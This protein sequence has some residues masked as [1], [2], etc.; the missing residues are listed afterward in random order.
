MVDIGKLY[1]SIY[2]SLIS[3]HN[4]DVAEKEA[5]EKSEQERMQRREEQIGIIDEKI[6]EILPYQ[7]AAQAFTLVTYSPSQFS[8]KDIDIKSLERLYYMTTTDNAQKQSAWDTLYID[9][10]RGIEYNKQLRIKLTSQLSTTFSSKSSHQCNDRCKK[11]LKGTQVQRLIG[12]I[13]EI[14]EKYTPRILAAKPY[15]AP[16]SISTPLFGMT[17]KPFPVTDGCLSLTKQLF[18]GYFLEDD[19]TL[20]LPCT[21]S[22]TTLFQVVSSLSEK[23]MS[24]IR[25]YIIPFLCYTPPTQYLVHYIDMCLLDSSAL[26]ILSPLEGF[27]NAICPVPTSAKEALSELSTL[28]KTVV[29]SDERSA[30][31]VVYRYN[32]SYSDQQINSQMQ[33]LCANAAHYNIK[34][35]IVQE[36]SPKAGNLDQVIP[37]W[38]DQNALIVRYGARRQ[39]LESSK[40]HSRI[41]VYPE[42]SSLSSDFINSLMKAYAPKPVNT[43]YFEVRQ[44]HTIRSNTQRN[45]KKPI[46]LLYGIGDHG[47]RIFLNLKETDFAAYILGNAGSGKSNLLN[48]LV[49]S[50]VMDYHPDDLE[51]WLVDFGRTEFT[52]YIKHTPPHIRYI[53]V[54]KSTELVCSLVDKLIEEMKYR[55]NVLSQNNALKIQDLPESVQL[56]MLLLVI[57]EFGVFKEVITS[58]DFDES[59]KYR[60]YMERLLKQGRKHGMYFIFANQS[61]TDV[62]KALPEEGSDQIGL[63]LA[64]Q[65]NEGEARAVLEMKGSQI[66]EAEER[67]LDQLPKYEVVYRSR[68]ENT[69]LSKRV[70]VLNLSG[71]NVNTQLVAIDAINSA[72]EPSGK[73]RMDAPNYYFPRQHLFL[74]HNAIPTFQ[75]RFGTIHGD[76]LQWMQNQASKPSDLLLYLGVPHNL[77]SVHH[78]LLRSSQAENLLLYGDYAKDFERIAGVVASIVNSARF[79]N[80]PVEFWGN[81]TDLLTEMFFKKWHAG[82]V[83]T[84]PETLVSR[85][86]ELNQQISGRSEGKRLVVVSSLSVSLQTLKAEIEERNYYRN[87]KGEM[88]E[89][90]FQRIRDILASGQVP[91][92]DDT[93]TGIED[94]SPQLGPLMRIGPRYGIHFVVV[95]QKEAELDEANLAMNHFSHY[96]A[97]ASGL[98]DSQYYI[99]KRKVNSISEN[100][101]L[102]CLTG[103]G[104]FTVYM[105]FAS[106]RKEK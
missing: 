4:D 19:Q 8:P 38:F 97:F 81:D 14:N 5:A 27:E 74:D 50:A 56:P 82:V 91:E 55:G 37:D 15:I 79:Q 42:P 1:D 69:R 103:N 78:E 3:I 93:G 57:D 43:N 106:N 101:M 36:V 99:F 84:D 73:T 54:E 28:R 23:V 17:A 16:K 25:A 85:V 2:N 52:R 63:R 64:M 59:K 30:H 20:L 12:E 18:G 88:S 86:Q 66:S 41:A 89:I 100:E 31:L 44:M 87:G 6:E 96:A 35:I 70:K 40:S 24:A 51:L 48:V 46:S 9:A 71:A 60:D 47:E 102:G 49:T 13:K 77:E 80:W 95:V 105:P 75:E 39:C 72:F 62:Y 29:D 22:Y 76:Y 53:L 10:S 94:I 26:G 45:R 33:W 104:E 90:G 21:L 32:Q 65:A 11:V 68:E 7:R 67:S 98:S 83:V 58:D 61:F 34:V 92:A